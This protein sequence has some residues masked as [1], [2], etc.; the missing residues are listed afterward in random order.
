MAQSGLPGWR[1]AA[2][3]AGYRHL[4][5]APLYGNE[6]LVGEAIAPWISEHGRDS[7]FLTTK[8]WNTAH[9]P[10]LARCAGDCQPLYV[11]S[12]RT[13]RLYSG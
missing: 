8:I 12:F 13:L 1:R 4:D 10:E 6:A 11:V 2:L 9:R 3:E 7:L 5:C